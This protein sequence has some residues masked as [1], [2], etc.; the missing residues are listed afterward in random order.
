MKKFLL[1][2]LIAVFASCSTTKSG[3]SKSL[4]IVGPGVIH[5]PVIA[6]L[7]VKQQKVSSTATFSQ[8]KSMANVR[9]E[10]IR[11]A[12]KEN[13]A[14]VLVEPSFESVTKNGKTELTVTGWPASYKN[15]R[16]IE[17]KDLKLLEVKPNLLQKAEVNETT[18]E[19]KKNTGLLITLGALLIGGLVAAAAL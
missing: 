4:D 16:Q 8:V 9:N 12:L 2:I 11:K 19:K 18:V 15:F 10:V 14:D 1:L 17:E 5:K 7:D 3:T 13:N 6:D